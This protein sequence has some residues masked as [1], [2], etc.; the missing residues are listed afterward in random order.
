MS[1][2][3]RKRKKW[4]EDAIE[5]IKLNWIGV[6]EFEDLGLE[7]AIIKRIG[8]FDLLKAIHPIK[9]TGNSKSVSKCDNFEYMNY[10]S[11][12][13]VELLSRCRQNSRQYA[14]KFAKE[15]FGDKERQEK[16]RVITF[17]YDTLI[18]DILMDKYKVPHKKLYFDRLSSEQC[19]NFNRRGRDK[20]RH[21]LILKLHGSANWRVS[22]DDFMGLVDGSVVNSEDKIP[23]WLERN[24]IPK[25]DD[26]ISPLILP[27]L[28]N[29]PITSLSIFCYLWQCAFE[30]LHETKRIVIA[31]YSCPITDSFAMSMLSQVKSIKV[32]E[33]VIVDKDSS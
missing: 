1:L 32:E 14:S 5:K 12:L 27:P 9:L 17:N 20:Y 30:Y 24:V 15:V 8:N 22:S 25:P 2:T 21:P 19:N 23:I 31:G 7:E 13:I 6:E 33:I 26:D 3:H 4:I 18:D 11:H 28:P 10:L 29:K 16:N